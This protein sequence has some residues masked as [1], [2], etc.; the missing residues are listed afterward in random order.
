LCRSSVACLLVRSDVAPTHPCRARARQQRTS[1]FVTLFLP[2]FKHK[3]IFEDGGGRDHRH[4][5]KEH[6]R[7]RFSLTRPPVCPPP[8]SPPVQSRSSGF[9]GPY[10]I[11]K[12]MEGRSCWPACLQT[13]RRQTC[14]LAG[15]RRVHGCVGDMGCATT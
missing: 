8:S 12:T 2:L 6:V 13:G 7:R 15:G 11:A 4:V 3:H 1:M 5:W 10:A 9:K 14:S